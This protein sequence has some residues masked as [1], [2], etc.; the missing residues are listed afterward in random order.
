MGRGINSPCRGCA[1]VSESA[2]PYDAELHS[3]GLAQY[4]SFGTTDGAA[5]H[6]CIVAGG[7]G[8]R[9]HRG[10]VVHV[11][12]SHGSERAE[13]CEIHRDHGAAPDPAVDVERRGN[14]STRLLIDR[15]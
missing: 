12:A 3:T 8:G 7:H 11:V 6:R 4:A 15:S 9:S 14:R 1:V 10:V 5:N 13:P 2:A